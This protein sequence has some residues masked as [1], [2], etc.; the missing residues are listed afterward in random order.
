VGVDIEGGGGGGVLR[1]TGEVAGDQGQFHDRRKLTQMLIPR[2]AESGFSVL[3]EGEEGLGGGRGVWGV[4]LGLHSLSHACA[5]D[6]ETCQSNVKSCMGGND[7]SSSRLPRL[8]G[9]F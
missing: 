9:L 2:R 8:L 1:E 7:S 5:R 6:A 4:G 3:Q